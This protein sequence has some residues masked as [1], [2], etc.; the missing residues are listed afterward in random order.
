M[1]R[2]IA[3]LLA[4]VMAL[5]L[6]ACGVLSSQADDALGDYS[7]VV[8]TTEEFDP[9]TVDNF[10]AEAEKI[11]ENMRDHGFEG[12]I[13]G[14]KPTLLCINAFDFSEEDGAAIFDLANEA[15]LISFSPSSAHR[16]S[17]YFLDYSVYDRNVLYCLSYEKG[18][19]YYIDFAQFTYNKKDRA[20]VKYLDELNKT[21]TE[22]YAADDI[23]QMEA[24]FAFLADFI[25][26]KVPVTV[27]G[28]SM[29][30]SDFSPTAIVLISD[31]LL[32]SGTIVLRSD[33]DS[34]VMIRFNKEM[35][36]AILPVLNASLDKI[37]EKLEPLYSEYEAQRS[38]Y[39]GSY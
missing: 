31:L 2:W 1:K 11:A 19:S 8:L 6:T 24:I 29:Y 28:E 39:F 10:T 23:Q 37:Y 32:Y 15:R 3:L 34:K 25:H 33:T 14:I 30:L 16:E 9:L 26:D 7:N 13:T 12:E 27:D 36:D 22:L 35:N 4:L 18:N 21:L 5:S 20:L 17:S 38:F